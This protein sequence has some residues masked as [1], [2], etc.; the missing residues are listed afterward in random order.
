MAA[1]GFSHSPR[2]GWWAHPDP[3]SLQLVILTPTTTLLN[4]DT[5][6]CPR[7]VDVGA[8]RP[9]LRTPERGLSTSEACHGPLARLRGASPSTTRT[10]TASLIFG[11]PRCAARPAA[12]PPPHDS[13]PP[14]PPTPGHAPPGSLRRQA[15]PACDGLAYCDGDG[16]ASSWSAYSASAVDAVLQLVI[17]AVCPV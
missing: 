4:D 1:K 8:L 12:L 11:K 17:S 2:P 9:L 6:P 16:D 5:A 3:P 10:W 13:A 14:A 15:R 7:L